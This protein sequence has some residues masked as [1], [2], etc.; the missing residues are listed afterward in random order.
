MQTNPLPLNPLPVSGIILAGGAGRRMGGIDKGWLIWQDAPLITQAISVLQQDCQEIFISANR[1]L[2]DY[3]ALGYPVITD[4]QSGYEGPL[5]GLQA[6]LAAATQEWVASIPVDSPLLPH[7]I[8]RQMWAAKGPSDLVVVRSADH[9]HA[10][11]LLCRRTLSAHLQQYLDSGERRARGWFQG[12][13]F[14]TLDL[15]ET[16]LRNANKPGDLPCTR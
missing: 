10:V 11:I 14:T 12:L 3:R 2:E 6:G 7:D 8:V 5:M 9:W 16:C 15:D 4:Q 13:N 1:H